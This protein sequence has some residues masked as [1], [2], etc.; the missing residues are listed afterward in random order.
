MQRV[1]VAGQNGSYLG[2]VDVKPFKYLAPPSTGVM[3]PGGEV[4]SKC[5]LQTV[6]DTGLGISITGEAGLRGLQRQFT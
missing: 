5:V 2:S 1:I 4:C 6:L 3:G